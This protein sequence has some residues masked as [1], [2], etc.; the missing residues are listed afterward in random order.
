MPNVP[1]PRSR[2]IGGRTGLINKDQSSSM[3]RIAFR[4]CFHY[5]LLTFRVRPITAK[6][7]SAAD[8]VPLENMAAKGLIRHSFPRFHDMQ[9]HP[10]NRP[11]SATVTGFGRALIAFGDLQPTL[12]GC[13][14][15]VPFCAT[16]ATHTELSPQNA[17]GA[18]V[19]ELVAAPE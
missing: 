16:V 13:R 19:S 5:S 11:G 7:M 18:T 6:A 4:Y 12:N 2:F 14:Y 10:S 8:S 3:L 17:L 1:L 9:N 15:Q